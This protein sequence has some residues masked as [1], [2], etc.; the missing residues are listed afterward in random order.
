MPVLAIPA[1][2]GTHRAPAVGPSWPGQR[3]IAAIDARSPFDASRPSGRGSRPLVRIRPAAGARGAG[4]QGPAVA[5]QENRRVRSD[6]HR[7]RAVTSGGAR[8]VVFGGRR[9]LTPAC[10]SATPRREIAKVAATERAGLV[11]TTLR[12][13]RDWFGPRRGSISYDVLSEVATPVLALP[14]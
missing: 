9:R 2:P 7:P 13:P 10:C 3:I 8:G 6:P 5:A 14:G 12:T 4:I 11:I 1:R